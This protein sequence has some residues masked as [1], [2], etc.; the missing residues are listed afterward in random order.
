MK[1]KLILIGMTTFTLVYLVYVALYTSDKKIEDG[2]L[3]NCYNKNLSS[4]VTYCESAKYLEGE[5]YS[6][7]DFFQ[8]NIVP[9]GYSKLDQEQ[10][11][12]LYNGPDDIKVYLEASNGDIVAISYKSLNL[13]G[14]DEDVYYN[15][16]VLGEFIDSHKLEI[17]E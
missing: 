4:I 6:G 1:K 11:R 15:E 8:T 10:F 12:F 13:I 14:V 3:N 16:Y 2:E 7:I 5:I 9:N 17:E